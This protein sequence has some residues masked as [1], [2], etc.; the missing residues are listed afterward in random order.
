MSTIMI[1]EDDT[2]IRNVLAEVLEDEG[3]TTHGAANGALALQALAS[4]SRPD[5][6]ITDIMMPVMDGL[7]LCAS[8]QADPAT[9]SIPIMLM[10]AGNNQHLTDGC[11]C[12]A[13]LAKPFLITTVLDMVSTVLNRDS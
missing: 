8:V 11:R 4:T 1:V 9:A 12:A 13:F 6:I 3:Y 7:R 10:S 2:Q 5:L